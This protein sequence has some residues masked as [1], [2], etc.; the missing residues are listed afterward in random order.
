MLS[1]SVRIIVLCA[2]TVCCVFC[3]PSS[4]QPYWCKR[5]ASHK[6]PGRPIPY[7][8]PIEIDL[9]RSINCVQARDSHCM[10]CI[11]GSLFIANNFTYSVLALLPLPGRPRG[12]SRAGNDLAWRS[13][14]TPLADETSSLCPRPQRSH[15]QSGRTPSA[16]SRPRLVSVTAAAVAFSA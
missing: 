14:H 7:V 6:I 11:T 3:R 15:L 8:P 2:T 5:V 16:Y 12:G 4:F 1:S 9:F 13:R 10:Q